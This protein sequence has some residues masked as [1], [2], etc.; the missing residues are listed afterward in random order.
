MKK[1]LLLAHPGFRSDLKCVLSFPGVHKHGS[2]VPTRASHAFAYSTFTYVACCR[3]W[4][5]S[6]AR[7]GQPMCLA[8]GE[9]SVPGRV[10]GV[11]V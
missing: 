8:T 9:P 6:L 11:G 7:L 5:L 1:A 3:A 2:T 4:S 10:K